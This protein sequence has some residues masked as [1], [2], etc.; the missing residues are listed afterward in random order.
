MELLKIDEDPKELERLIYEK[1]NDLK[2]LDDT[3]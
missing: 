2:Y 3:F 1:V